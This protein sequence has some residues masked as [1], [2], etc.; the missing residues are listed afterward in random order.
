MKS[1]KFPS[2]IRQ[3]YYFK[4]FEFTPRYYNEEKE[5]LELR[6]REIKLEVES[7]KKIKDDPTIER[8]ARMRIGMETSWQNRRSREVKKSNIR[9]AVIL[10][11]IVAILFIIKNK[12]GI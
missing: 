6:K 12:L 2:L 10:A 7:E 11:I 5:K 1:P 8:H 4:R 9:I 3:N